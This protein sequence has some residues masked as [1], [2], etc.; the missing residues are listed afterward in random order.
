LVGDEAFWYDSN[1][2]AVPASEPRPD[3]VIVVLDNDGAG[4]FSTLEQGAAPYRSHFER[5][6][7]TPLD[8][9]L[10]EL[11]DSYGANVHTAT[12]LDHLQASV[13][14]RLSDGVHVVVLRTCERARE[15]EVLDSIRDAVSQAISSG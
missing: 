2:L 5:I 15:A 7:G 9:K 8:I 4:I 14:E 13:A 3:L 10:A 1:A 6:F 12:D 11:A